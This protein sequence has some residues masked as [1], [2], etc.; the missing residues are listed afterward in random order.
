MGLL[1]SLG[2]AL[3]S[4]LSTIVSLPV[5][6]VLAVFQVLKAILEKLGL[7]SDEAKLLFS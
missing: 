5:L 7:T 1:S 2:S 6:E 3:S 4:V